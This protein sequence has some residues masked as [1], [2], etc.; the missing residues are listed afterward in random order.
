METGL[1]SVS[2]A[3]ACVENRIGGDRRFFMCAEN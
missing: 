3:D 1:N 2:D